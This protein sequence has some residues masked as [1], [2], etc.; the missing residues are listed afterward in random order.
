MKRLV[1]LAMLLMLAFSGAESALAT[2][3]DFGP[4]IFDDQVS[5]VENFEKIAGSGTDFV[6]FQLKLGDFENRYVRLIAV[7]ET[8]AALNLGLY[9]SGGNLLVDAANLGSTWGAEFTGNLVDFVVKW[10]GLAG[11]GVSLGS[12]HHVAWQFGDDVTYIPEGYSGILLS[13][14]T[15]LFGLSLDGSNAADFIIAIS[16]APFSP[17]PVPAAAWLM[18]SGVAGLLALRKRVK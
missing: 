16:D 13:G 18:G 3:Y 7:S 17:V 5:I 1:M 12:T 10:D 9:T 8:A 4:S 11:N 2:S 15:M 14:G 6:T